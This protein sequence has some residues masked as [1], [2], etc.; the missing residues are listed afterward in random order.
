MQYFGG[1]NR[2]G[3]QLASV[4]NKYIGDK[5]FY[6]LFTGSGGVEQYIK[7]N[8]KYY[9][10]L[11]PFL[12]ILYDELVTG[13]L[14]T[15]QEC[16][17]LLNVDFNDYYSKEIE[18]FY[19]SINR[20]KDLFDIYNTRQRAYICMIGFSCGYGGKWMNG[21]ARNKTKDNYFKTGINSLQKKLDNDLF[22]NLRNFTTLDYKT[23]AN[24]KNAVVYCDPPYDS[25][26]GFTTGKFDNNEFWEFATNLSKN[27]IVFISEYKA[28]ENFQAI[29][30]IKF[31]KGMRGKNKAGTW[32]NAKTNELLIV[33]KSLIL[34]NS[35]SLE[36]KQ[37]SFFDKEISHYTV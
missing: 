36:P 14:P 28:H 21:F 23:Y 6:S 3:R 29:K 19:F 26:T 8:N 33:H 10:D 25:T 35:V 1:K 24:I 11:H 34:N 5:D 30:T 31:T 27:N 22:N 18:N 2:I 7:A 15:I 13:W 4:I 37:L 20:R 9:N 17:D 32:L 12:K 16:S